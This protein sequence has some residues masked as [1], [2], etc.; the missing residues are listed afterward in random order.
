[1]NSHLKANLKLI[2]TGILA[3]LAGIFGGVG[4]LAL[5]A[6]IHKRRNKKKKDE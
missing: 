6:F 3:I 2:L 1:M 4:G 5:I